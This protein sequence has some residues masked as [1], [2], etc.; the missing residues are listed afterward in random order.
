MSSDFFLV[1]IFLFTYHLKP[2][3][4]SFHE[5]KMLLQH[6]TQVT[7]EHLNFSRANLTFK[8]PGAIWAELVQHVPFRQLTDLRAELG[9]MT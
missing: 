6:D 2:L 8:S 4:L 1:P 7:H 5:V 3:T 9:C